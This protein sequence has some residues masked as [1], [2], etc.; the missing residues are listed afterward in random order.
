ML[1]VRSPD[2]H[3]RFRR[4]IA[5]LTL[6]VA[7][8]VLGGLTTICTSDVI[9]GPPAPSG[10]P[11]SAAI[12]DHTIDSLTGRRLLLESANGLIEPWSWAE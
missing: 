11:R 1:D 3:A 8:V 12:A 6:M 2:F 4:V 5:A 10:K 9:D 7:T